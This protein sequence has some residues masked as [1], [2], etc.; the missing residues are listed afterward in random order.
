MVTTIY[1]FT[2]TGN[3]LKIARSLSEMLEEC[4]LVP[5]AK[6]WKLESLEST[7]EKI[8][9]IFPLYFHGVP[10]IVYDFLEKVNLNKSTYFFA[11][12]TLAGDIEGVPLMQIEKFLR[13]KSKNLHAG[14]FITMPTNYILGY[15]V[16]SEEQ[17]KRFFK[18]ANKKVKEIAEIVKE[19]GKNIDSDILKNVNNRDER[20]NK[21]FRDEV[22]ENDKSFYANDYCTNCGICEQVCPVNN[23]IIVDDKPQWQHGCQLCLACIHYC[24]EKSIQYG[25][26]TLKAGRYHH[27]EVSVND[28]ISQ[29]K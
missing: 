8:G 17:Q 1:Y 22:N 20:L 23:I 14:F 27:P 4:E 18:I 21:D 16:H 13:A 19:N 9:F 12:V 10:K 6:V 15:N 7:S 26:E 5:I 29:K 25:V 11:I 2:G 3:S 24:P 28:L